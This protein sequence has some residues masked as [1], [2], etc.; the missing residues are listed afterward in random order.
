M[1]KIFII[2]FTVLILI[3]ISVTVLGYRP[4]ITGSLETGDKSYT[5]FMEGTEEIMDTYDYEKVW[6]KYKQK[7]APYEYYYI[8]TQY[9]K[10]DYQVEDNYNNITL[11]F[12]SNYTYYLRDHLRNKWNLD[13]KDKDYFEKRDK[14]YQTYKMKCQFDYEY[15]DSNKYIFYIQRQWNQYIVDYSKDNIKDKFSIEWKYDV[16]SNLEFST[17][18]QLNNQKFNRISDSTNKYGKKV[19]IDFKYKL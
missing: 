3:L 15:D 4:E 12:Y 10:K 11:N 18:F 6:I 2:I 13:F 17:N 19:S 5:E 9:S 1:K 16:N 14:S 8:K 7:F